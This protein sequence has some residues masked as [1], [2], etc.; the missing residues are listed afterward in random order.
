MHLCDTDE[1]MSKK[2]LAGQ[3]FLSEYGLKLHKELSMYTRL[4]FKYTRLQTTLSSLI[5]MDRICI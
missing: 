5:H 3:V 1:Y 2:N 4:L